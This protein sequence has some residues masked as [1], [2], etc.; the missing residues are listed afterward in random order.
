MVTRIDT[1]FSVTRHRELHRRRRAIILHLSL[2][3]SA[4]AV[5]AALLWWYPTW[6]LF[7]WITPL[8]AVTLIW[9]QSEKPSLSISR[10]ELAVLVDNKLET[11]ERFQTFAYLSRS[12]AAPDLVRSAFIAHQIEESLPP[13]FSPH[14]I[15]ST[16]L[17][18]HQRIELASIITCVVIT[19]TLIL[20]RPHP[21]L[22]NIAARIVQI[23]QE[24]PSLP[25]NLKQSALDT[26]ALLTSGDLQDAKAALEQTRDE[27]SRAIQEG[28]EAHGDE[29]SISAPEH[30]R[31]QPPHLV[32]KQE[33]PTQPQTPRDKNTETP[34]HEK[35]P[36]S[37]KQ[38]EPKPEANQNEKQE[39]SEQ[40]KDPSQSEGSE[41]SESSGDKKKTDDD[42][43]ESKENSSSQE[44]SGKSQ[45]SSQSDSK[46]AEEGEGQGSG[47]G[48][49]GSGSGSQGEGQQEGQ[50]T[51]KSSGKG[52]SAQGSGAGES[53]G[54]QG[55]DEKQADS[56]Q[57]Q[58]DQQKSGAAGAN[59]LK[60]L[61][62][63]MNKAEQE[64]EKQ[65][66][67]QGKQNEGQQGSK[68]EGE[69]DKGA[70]SEK[71]QSKA[72][73]DEGQS[74]QQGKE[75]KEPKDPKEKGQGKDA[76]QTSSRQD[77]KEGNGK[78]ASQ[79]KDAQDKSENKGLPA[80]NANPST[81]D[82]E[83]A[84]DLPEGDLSEGN[85]EKSS[86]PNR[87][88][89]AVNE[90]PGEGPPSDIPKGPLG[91]KESHMKGDNEQFDARFTGSD[92]TLEESKAPA[93]AKTTLEDVLLAKPRG[94][95]QKG[96]QPIPLEYK[97]ILE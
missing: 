53:S 4:L 64:I 32:P 39:N 38:K 90:V 25:E 52:K 50:Q 69:S 10:E 14:E 41:Q 28:L 51:Q 59:G 23:V 42:K 89:Q 12:A 85:G 55:G 96:K 79:Q 5:P 63:A 82:Q 30:L 2:I 86:M 75:G 70:P 45:S 92:S 13:A 29:T 20:F 78:G 49:S 3:A 33:Q 76:S 34:P 37:D 73:N 62:A 24:N 80:S 43:K 88:A 17:T 91:F 68:G 93:H 9:K 72:G 31:A 54:E 35:K 57:T 36:Q 47:Q 65:E 22:E 95:V 84:K 56:P 26:A 18:S 15:V 21:P 8:G 58:G 74:S 48:S 40:Q 97:G 94:S 87:E 60:D 19:L 61:N 16:K 46:E 6:T 77:P 81:T 67:S 83:P 44:Q 66:D 1:I 71:K 27:I 11:K 7:L